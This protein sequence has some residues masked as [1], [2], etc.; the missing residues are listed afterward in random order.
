MGNRKTWCKLSDAGGRVLLS[1]R[2]AFCPNATQLGFCKSEA[3]AGDLVHYSIN[4]DRSLARV[5]GVIDEVEPA[6]DYPG[7]APGDLL[8]L[9]LSDDGT[10]AYLRVVKPGEVCTVHGPQRLDLLAWFARPDL[11]EDAASVGRYAAYGSLS[12]SYIADHTREG[13]LIPWADGIG[14]APTYRAPKVKAEAGEC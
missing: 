11:A 9:R 8:V 13:K 3:R 14:Q 2:G 5:L 6:S 4:G 1:K 12:A 7:I 10:F